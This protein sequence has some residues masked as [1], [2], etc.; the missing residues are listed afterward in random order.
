MSGGPFNPREHF[1][2][3]PPVNGASSPVGTVTRREAVG[4]RV[5][6][7]LKQRTDQPSQPQKPSQK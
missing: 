2:G 4:Q 7:G 6:S 1:E 5:V 3:Y